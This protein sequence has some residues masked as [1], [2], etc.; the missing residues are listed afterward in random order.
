MAKMKC[1]HIANLI[2]DTGTGGHV[3]IMSYKKYCLRA[4]HEGVNP[5][6]LTQNSYATLSTSILSQPAWRSALKNGQETQRLHNTASLRDIIRLCPKKADLWFLFTDNNTA[7][8]TEQHSPNETHSPVEI[9]RLYTISPA[10]TLMLD[11]SLT[12]RATDEPCCEQAHIWMAHRMSHTTSNT[13]RDTDIPPPTPEDSPTAPP[14]PSLFTNGIVAEWAILLDDHTTPQP[15]PIGTNPSNFTCTYGPIDNP[16]P[17]TPCSGTDVFHLHWLQLSPQ[18]PPSRTLDPNYTPTAA[19]SSSW[20]T[21]LN[22]PNTPIPQVRNELILPRISLG[23][24]PS[25][26]DT[27]Y[28]VQMDAFHIGPRCINPPLTREICDLCWYLLGIQTPE[29]TRHI[30]FECPF[31]TPCEAAHR[32]LIARCA[33]P[34]GKHD[35]AHMSSL[36]FITTFTHRILFGCTKFEDPI[37]KCPP[38]AVVTLTAATQECLLHRRNT[39]AR[40]D[41]HGTPLTTRIQTS[42]PALILASPPQLKP[43]THVPNPTTTDSASISHRKTFPK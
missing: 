13:S 4:E 14:P 21:L 12:P 28:R 29:H 37:F 43:H 22:D 5:P 19:G 16:P 18:W 24:C 23:L 38:E 35:I 42:S 15:A 30:L 20:A 25:L 26:K 17:P 41:N 3:H 34:L 10:G 1:T 7:S 8:Q 39:N 27:M 6:P 40:P 9:T 11:P 31:A 33:S 2:T 32:S 36:T